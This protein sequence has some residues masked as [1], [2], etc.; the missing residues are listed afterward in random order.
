MDNGKMEKGARGSYG[1]SSGLSS[2]ERNMMSDIK[3]PDDFLAKLYQSYS[4]KQRRAGLGCFLSA[5]IIFDLWAILVPQ[6]Q[7]CESLSMF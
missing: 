5:S 7:S 1:H 6:G 4:I 3:L 2:T